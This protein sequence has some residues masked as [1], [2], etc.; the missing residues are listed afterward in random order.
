MFR[1]QELQLPAV[2]DVQVSRT[3]PNSLHKVS[4]LVVL[5]MRLTKPLLQE[6]EP[7]KIDRRS[8]LSSDAQVLVRCFFNFWFSFSD[9]ICAPIYNTFASR[10]TDIHSLKTLL[11]I[12]ITTHI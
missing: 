4:K 5:S 8:T 1:P 7:P 3:K 2:S 10:H 9:L 12:R 6:N 11:L